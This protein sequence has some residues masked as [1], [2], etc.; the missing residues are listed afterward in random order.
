MI[1]ISEYSTTNQYVGKSCWFKTTPKLIFCLYLCIYLHVTNHHP[2]SPGFFHISPLSHQLITVNRKW[3]WWW[4]SL[5]SSL[6]SLLTSL[7]VYVH[8]SLPCCPN[9]LRFFVIFRIP[10]SSLLYAE[11][12]PCAHFLWVERSFCRYSLGSPTC[13]HHFFRC[14]QSNT[15]P[16]YIK[17][18]NSPKL[19]QFLFL[20]HFPSWNHLGA[21]YY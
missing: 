11:F 4:H 3:K 14:P 17:S 12:L 1:P 2:L 18:F 7:H 8:S 10:R 21:F 20:T 16:N 6:Y 9:T 15:S 13:L 5:L 19:T